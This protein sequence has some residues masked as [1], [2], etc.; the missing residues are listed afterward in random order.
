M[1]AARCCSCGAWVQRWT[2]VGG[3]HTCPGCFESVNAN[4]ARVRAAA[5][6]E[7]HRIALEAAAA[8]L[9]SGL[10]GEWPKLQ[11]AFRAHG[12]PVIV[13]MGAR[14]MRERAKA[15]LEQVAP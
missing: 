4:H 12:E 10:L 11:A 9:V 5:R 15:L 2:L 14:E 3:R 13:L 7:Q 1:T 8:G 6:Q